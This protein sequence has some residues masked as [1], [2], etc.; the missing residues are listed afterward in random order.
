MA[1]RRAL[2]EE[3]DLVLLGLEAK[4]KKALIDIEKEREDYQKCDKI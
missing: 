1:E 2:K 4:K 3:L